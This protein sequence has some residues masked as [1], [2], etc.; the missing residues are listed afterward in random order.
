MKSSMI[1]SRWSAG[2]LALACGPV[3]ALSEQTH[4]PMPV[5]MDALVPACV[6]A[7]TPTCGL[8]DRAG[9]WVVRSDTETFKLAGTHWLA[10]H[11]EGGMRIF[12]AKGRQTGTIPDGLRVDDFSE[13]LAS[14]E[15]AQ[16][17]YGFLN[18]KGEV[19]VP[20][21]YE[22]VRPFSQGRAVVGTR[23]REDASSSYRFGYI[24]AHGK[25]VIARTYLVANSFL[26][27][28]AA[29]ELSDHGVGAIDKT[30]RL[31]VPADTMRASLDVVGP[32][33]LVAHP[34][35]GRAILM[36]GKGRELIE[37]GQER[38][39]QGV[40]NGIAV[41][42]AQERARFIDAQGD[43][44]HVSYPHQAGSLYSERTGPVTTMPRGEDVVEWRDANNQPLFIRVRLDCG[45]EQLRDTGGRPL[46][47]VEDVAE[48]CILN[49]QRRNDTP[50][51]KYVA[52][53][54]PARMAALAP[55]QPSREEAVE[56]S[57]DVYRLVESAATQQ[58]ID[59]AVEQ[60]R[61][62]RQWK[63]GATLVK[64]LLAAVALVTS[65]GYLRKRSR[66]SAASQSE[67]NDSVH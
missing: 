63:H 47:P 59:A 61:E 48:R 23:D 4:P 18:V 30:G 52:A 39:P 21:R 51:P 16:G 60:A 7:A 38:K 31:V 26:H 10:T 12:D 34:L 24:D 37:R 67:G 62:D 9:R 65:L 8:L 54:D 50:D 29:V 3:L 43:Q 25:E 53:A 40:S 15:D 27:G 64:L 44:L 57:L 49:A 11:R 36:D 35:G 6:N 33:R 13:G 14:F 32:D 45:I 1:I 28:L 17:K 22:S 5:P 20:A 66:Q 41:V 55:P 42:T 58:R 19:A 56:A 46:W 2:L